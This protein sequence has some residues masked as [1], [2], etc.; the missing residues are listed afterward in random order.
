[1]LAHLVALLRHVGR[2]SSKE[3]SQHLQ[4]VARMAE[5]I[6]HASL[7]SITHTIVASPGP[8]QDRTADMRLFLNFGQRSLS[9][10]HDNLFSVHCGVTI[11]S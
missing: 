9:L 2:K 11:L 6:A 8:S 3:I 1:L 7:P 4:D 10:S 5:A